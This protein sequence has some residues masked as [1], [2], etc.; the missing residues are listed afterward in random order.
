VLCCSLLVVCV[1]VVKQGVFKGGKSMGGE[2][3][4]LG[5]SQSDKGSR[6]P[7]KTQS[8]SLTRPLNSFFFVQETI[9]VIG[10]FPSV[11]QE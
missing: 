7:E 1:Q 3:I 4:R 9:E 11:I 10:C 5:L 2:L 8:D 6:E